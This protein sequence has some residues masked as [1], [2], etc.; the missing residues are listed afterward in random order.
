MPRF[1]HVYSCVFRLRKASTIRKFLLYRCLPVCLLLF[2]TLHGSFLTNAHAQSSTAT[3]SG[4]VIDQTGA[5]IPGV[6]I[7]VISIAQ[8]F[9]RN[10]TTNE[11]GI[12]IVAQLPPG[13]YT[14]KAEHDGFTPAE[15]RD[16]ILNVNDQKTIKV[17]LKV[18]NISQ[19]VEIVDGSSLIDDSAAVGTVVDRRFVSNLPL[20]GRSFQSLIALTPSVVLTK[21]SADNSGQFSVNGQRG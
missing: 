2:P 9:Q 21:A 13:S 1:P 18:G 19:T 4:I 16:V 8:G 3:L 11:E 5:V 15:V 12:F 17:Y 10:A 7:A 20:N 6:K 14:V